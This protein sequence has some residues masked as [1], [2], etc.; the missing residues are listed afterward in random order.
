MQNEYLI[1]IMDG[2]RLAGILHMPPVE[3]RPCPVVVYCP[4]KNGERY[5]V[6]RLAVKFAR[7]LMERGIGFLRFD[8]YGIGLS[9]GYYY[10]MTTSKKVKNVLKA[11]E[12]IRSREDVRHDQLWLLGFSDGA[13]VALLAANQEKISQLLLWSPLFFETGGNFP[14][15]K[16]P[17]FVRHQ[18]KPKHL[19][20]AWAG[21]WVGMDFYY[22]LKSWSI[23]DEIRNYRGKSLIIYGDDDPLVKEEFAEQHINELH[24]YEN[25][26][27]HQV[28]VLKDAGHLFNS[29]THEQNLMRLSSEWLASDLIL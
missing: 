28:Q 29:C 5:E 7:L 17:K 25:S 12:Y 19:V 18:T 2:D 6:H 26:N 11:Y 21:L 1:D 15:G 23:K 9:D 3:Q 27:L 13:R 20:M 14:N 10:E 22:D 8:Y 24:L 16:H 4:G